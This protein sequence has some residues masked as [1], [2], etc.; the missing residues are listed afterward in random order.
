MTTLGVRQTMLL[1]ILFVAT[2]VT[3]IA[4]DSRNALGPLKTGLH[5]VVSPAVNFV[6]DLIDRGEPGGGIQAE[7]QQVTEE[8]DALLAENAQLKQQLQGVE[9]LRDVLEVQEDNPNLTLVTA[10]V[11]NQDPA[12]LQKFIIIDQGADDGIEVGM[13]VI[14][15]FYLVGVVTEVEQGSA[16]V[17]LAIDATFS[18]GAQL[19]DSR[20]VGVAYGRWQHGGRIE[21]RHV[22]RDH[23]PEE[24]ELVVTSATGDAQTAKVPGGWII[25]KVTGPISV[26]NQSDSLTIPVLPAS[27]FDNLSVVAVIVANAHE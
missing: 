4:L 8:R 26:D 19:L 11:I 2:S 6:N 25:G 13:A 10:N 18:I 7:L 3:L 14:D 27:N 5:D 17:T 21:L 24:G 20:G 9:Q 15:P 12:G 22:E 1:V 23:M 16:K